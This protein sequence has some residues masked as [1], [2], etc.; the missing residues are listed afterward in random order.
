MPQRPRRQA[1]A[2]AAGAAAAAACIQG[3]SEESSYC[4]FSQVGTGMGTVCAAAG[5]RSA[6]TD[7][8]CS[9]H[10]S[11]QPA[12]AGHLICKCRRRPFLDVVWQYGGG[13]CSAVAGGAAAGGSAAAAAASGIPST[14]DGV[15]GAAGSGS[16]GRVSSNLPGSLFASSALRRGRLVNYTQ[17]AACWFNSTKWAHDSV[18]KLGRVSCGSLT[19]ES[20]R[21]VACQPAEPSAAAQPAG[22]AS[23]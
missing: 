11:L 19:H 18:S 20:R 13:I 3:L 23:R 7:A 6:C 5:W 4:V 8:A 9:L 17:F 15:S 21:V 12:A 1:S 2:A 10:S 16:R 22:P 14:A